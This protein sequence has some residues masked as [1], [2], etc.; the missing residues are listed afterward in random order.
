MSGSRSLPAAAGAGA[1]AMQLSPEKLTHVVT[2]AVHAAVAQVQAL[3]PADNDGDD[4]G[5]GDM[6]DGADVNGGGALGVWTFNENDKWRPV[7]CA[8][9]VHVHD[10]IL[11]RQDDKPDAEDVRWLFDNTEQLCVTVL[12]I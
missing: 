1:M 2:T 5:D 4:D 11:E 7:K 10:A 8:V 6:V 9:H 3:Q 12:V